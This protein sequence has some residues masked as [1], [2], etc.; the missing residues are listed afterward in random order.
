MDIAISRPK[1][2]RKHIA[3]SMGAGAVVLV[4]AWAFA[5]RSPVSA[6]YIVDDHELVIGEVQRGELSVEVR[7]TGTLVPKD[8]HLMTT[9][10]EGRVVEI[11]AQAGSRV[12]DGDTVLRLSNPQLLQQL[13]AAQW[14]L[15]AQ[16]AKDSAALVSLDS[17]VLALED[18][19]LN[20]RLSYDSAL[21]RLNAQDE[22]VSKGNSAVSAIEHETTRLEVQQFAERLAIQQQ[23][24]TKMRDNQEAQKV[25]QAAELEKLQNTVRQLEDQVESLEVRATTEGVVQ[26][27]TLEL[28][29]RLTVGATIAKIARHDNLLARLQIQE[30]QVRDVAIGQ[31]VVIDTRKS[32]IPGA[33]IRIDPA[34]IN[35]VVH[36]DI[37]PTGDL[38]SEARPDLSVS[39][40]IQI[41]EISDT[42]YVAR[43]VFAQ[44]HSDARLYRLSADGE[45]AE[46]TQVRLGQASVAY[47]EVLDGLAPG[48]RVITSDP[49]A[50]ESHNIIQ[51]N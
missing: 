4:A 30:V 25:A 8:V 11:I 17:E 27:M 37:Q 28:G 42:L 9:A 1:S 44:G 23:R 43:P 24:L 31:P 33:V 15:K 10:V 14:D 34:V 36:V 32:R 41:S 18:Q 29:E 26:D 46:R 2:R 39:G 7:G 49:S 47:V 3:W 51:I 13:E 12:T 22:L 20:T 45:Y 40:T 5:G 35:G 6:G 21:L 48:D 38:P 50:W 19:V 16:R